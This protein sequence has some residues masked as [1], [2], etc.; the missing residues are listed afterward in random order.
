MFHPLV[1][2]IVVM[3]WVL[4]WFI[5]GWEGIAAIFLTSVV[6]VSLAVRMEKKNGN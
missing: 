3:F 2:A 6:G 1:W 5:V 4:A